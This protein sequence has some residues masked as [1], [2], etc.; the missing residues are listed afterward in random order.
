[1][2]MRKYKRKVFGHLRRVFEAPRQDV[3]RIL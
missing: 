1:L 2:K 3:S